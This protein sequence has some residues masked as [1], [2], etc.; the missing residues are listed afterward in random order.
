MRVQRLK[1]SGRHDS[2]RYTVP[3]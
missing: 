1:K 3:R 2:R